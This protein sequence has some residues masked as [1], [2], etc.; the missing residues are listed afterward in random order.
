MMTLG[1]G[2]A[3]LVILFTMGAVILEVVMRYLLQ[4]PTSWVLEVVEWCQVWMTFL[5][6]AWVLRK[7]AHVTMDMVSARLKPKPRAVLGIV[8]S[9]L[10]ALICLTMVW[11]GSQVVWDHFVRGVVQAS[12]LRAPKAPLLLII[13]VGFLLMFLQFLRR[14]RGLVRAS[15]SE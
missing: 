7:E 3:A 10:G 9:S 4:R 5:A 15:R 11:F 12:V 1:G 6:A 2:A 13:P 14:V 8:T